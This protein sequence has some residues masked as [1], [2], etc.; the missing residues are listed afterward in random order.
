MSATVATNPKRTRHL[1]VIDEGNDHRL[2]E[3]KASSYFVGRDPTNAIVLQSK[4]VSRQHAIFL[5]LT[6]TDPNEYGFLLIDGNLQGTASSN[7]TKVNGD[8]CLST[9]LCHGDQVRFGYH[10][11]AK[12]L[13]LPSLTNQE[14]DDYCAEGQ[15]EDLLSEVQNP[16]G[17]IIVDKP[18]QA[19]FAAASLVRLASFPE[20]IPSPMFE[21]NLKGE[22][23]YLN[24]AAMQFFPNLPNLGVRHPAMQGLL[25]LVKQSKRKILSREVEVVDKVFEQSIH[26]ISETSLIR[27]CLFDITQRKHAESELLKRD[28]LLQSVSHSTAH[29]L[30]NVDYETAISRA[31]ATFGEMADVDRI[32]IIANHLQEETEELMASLRFEWVHESLPSVRR[33]SHRQQQPYR[34]SYLERWLPILANGGTIRASLRD[35]PELEQQVLSQDGIHSVVVVPIMVNDNF[36]GFIELDNCT[37]EHVWSEQEE[38]I[39]WTLATSISAALQRQHKDEIIQQQAFHDA[40]TGLPN[41]ILFTDRLNLA[42]TEARRSQQSLAVMFMDL[43]RFKTINDTLGHSAGDALLQEVATRVKACLRDSD[44]V[45][46]WGGDEFTLLLPHINHI[47]DATRTAQRILEAFQEVIPLEGHDIYVNTSIGIAFYPSDGKEAETLLKNA[48]VALY[49][50]KERGR[51]IYQL[52]NRV[53]NSEASE[54]FVLRNGLRHAIERQELL[55]HYQPQL[56]LNSGKITGIE[57]LLRWHHPEKGMISPSTFIPLAEETGLIIDI[58]EWVLRTACQQAVDWQRQG[59]QPLSIA[60]NLSARQFYEPTLVDMIANILQETQLDPHCLEL[61]ITESIAIKNIDFA[62]SILQQ[63]QL[64][65]IRIAMD[66]FGTGYSSL[67]YLTQLPL[68]T[69]KI[70]RSFI[71]N[72]QPEAKELEIIHAVIALGRGLDL[73]VIA[74]GIDRPEQLD[75]LQSLQCPIV[76]GYL[77][78]RPSVAHEITTYLDANLR[79]D[80]SLPELQLAS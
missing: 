37:E 6:S 31:L 11:R 18:P 67:N 13:I 1:L 33:K 38:S 70:D 39:V 25:E 74:E 72:L 55:L 41:R 69:L 12:Y 52:Y 34:D 35:L 28:L 47:E 56:D 42:L 65:G 64:M 22:L 53:M 14:F 78:G 49:Q 23:T 8:P 7:G 2:I 3:L 68:N 20:I 71:Q 80:I 24:P 58:G 46:R 9:R 61:E 32:C 27:C 10:A 66:D 4:D 57:A 36:W 75:L 48:D 16:R 44:T 62:Q 79:Q 45:A 26:F 59:F 21:V 51:G 15:Y 40:L 77:T 43:D 17:T 50:A 19:N 5:R 63:I 60:V 30:T 54:Q 29:L 73:T 76:Q